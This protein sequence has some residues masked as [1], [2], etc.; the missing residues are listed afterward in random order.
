MN[1]DHL[2]P[3]TLILGVVYAIR[4]VV[5]TRGQRQLL[6]AAGGSAEL[7]KVVLGDRERQ[8]RL[9]TLRWGLVLLALALGFG[10][11][12]WLGW[13]EVSPGLIAVLAAATGVGHLAAWWV[14][15]RQP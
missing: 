2:V 15:G 5:E 6:L 14:I 3:I 13:Q 10:V 9:S 1:F 8:R 7:A 12:H 11:I 4:V